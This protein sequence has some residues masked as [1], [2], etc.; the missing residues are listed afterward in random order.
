MA[1]GYAPSAEDVVRR[2][3]PF[4]M[5]FETS[6]KDL[7]KSI[8][9][10]GEDVEQLQQVL[11]RALAECREE[12]RA[13]D[14]ELKA[15][16]VV[17]LTYLEMYG[18]D[19]AW[20]NF[21]ILEV[22]SSS[23]LRHKRVGYLAASQSFYKD[24]DVLMLATNLLKKDLR[25]E[26]RGDGR[27][28]VLT[29]GVT[30]SGLSTM[31]SAALARDICEDLFGMLGSTRPYIRKKAVAALFKV[32]LQFPEAL[33]DHFDRFA[34]RLRD[35]DLSV[36]SA[37]VSVV[38]ELSKKNP[39]PFVALSPLLYEMLFTIDNNWI[40][41]RLLKLFTNLAQEEPKLRVKILPKV[42]ELMQMTSATSVIYEAI[43][44]IVRGQ[45]LQEDDFDAASCCLQEL[46]KFCNSND[47]NLRYISVILFYKIGKINA[48]FIAEFDA[49]VI[50][51]LKD[52]DVSIRSRALE[53]LEG[54]TDDNNLATAVQI[55]IQQFVDKDVVSAS[56]LFRPVG[57]NGIEIEIPASYKTKM[58]SVILKICSSE[59]YAKISDFDWYI[60]VLSDLCVVSQDLISTNSSIGYQL[61][62]EIRTI[63]VKVPSLRAKFINT[64]AN[65]VLNE[66]ITLHMPMIL[67]EG[68]WCIGEYSAL[69]QDGDVFIEKSVM[70]NRVSPEVQQIMA[71]ALLK[72]FSNWCNNDPTRP[73]VHV[74][75]VLAKL[76]GFYE[77]LTTSQ[78]FEVQER[79]VEFLEFCKLC[80]ESLEEDDDQDL[81]LLIT[82]VLP[83]FFDAYDLNP[84]L[85]GTQKKIQKNLTLDLD[86]PFLD[87]DELEKLLLEDSSKKD[88]E[89]LLQSDM[90]LDFES[91]AES[92]TAQ[93][94][95]E[96]FS[97]PEVT[98]ELSA[99]ERH[100]L[101]QKRKQ[102]RMDNPFYLEAD[103]DS[104]QTKNSKLIDFGDDE[105]NQ[106]L[107]QPKSNST[108]HLSLTG[109]ATDDSTR[110]KKKKSK[111]KAQVLEEEGVPDLIDNPEVYEDPHKTLGS[112]SSVNSSAINLKVHSKLESFDF[113]SPQISPDPTPDA[114][115]DESA[116]ISKLRAKFASTSVDQENDSNDEVVV[117][118]KSK[119][120]SKSK[121][122]KKGFKKSAKKSS[123]ESLPPT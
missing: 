84:I 33:R 110:K 57:T 86:T 120:K 41:I 64:I 106:T 79:S 17:K 22:M 38:C 55:L 82:E 99:A 50:R 69:L 11:G 94:P 8:R 2:L 12:V 20:A 105:N 21:H 96:S 42:L 71:Q 104:S 13:P 18:F 44:C 5:L 51:L 100:A 112:G 115:T 95:H 59:N 60:A 70:H 24:V 78:S 111:R 102:D 46:N 123:E 114:D 53:L 43:N 45:M 26:G 47:P 73:I 113:T 68:Y 119:S 3:R 66:D 37:T 117:V 97:V 63:M 107:A 90:E 92:V 32:F 75:Q 85:H 116:D 91:D 58:V 36:V 29:M 48:Q 89:S 108:L 56:N 31:V 118:K 76:I 72:V 101:E 9:T 62:D 7:I 67:R 52:V 87:D 28:D 121:S 15:N 93:D 40:I 4:G 23:K 54:A 81:P 39:R 49:L 6:L 88:S 25:Y 83:G 122:K 65:L 34:A 80:D 10:A 27:H 14:V 16:A 74:K 1:S 30:L 35:E 109:T 61:A 103:D 98:K 19:M 77:S